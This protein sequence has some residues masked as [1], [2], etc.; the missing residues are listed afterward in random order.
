MPNSPW[1]ITGG[2]V[3][4]GKAEFYL[5]SGEQSTKVPIS[6]LT[7][8]SEKDGKVSISRD[9]ASYNLDVFPNFACPLGRFVQRDAMI[10][11]T[12]LDD[13]TDEMEQLIAGAGL[14]DS[15]IP[16]AYENSVA[17]EFAKTPFERLFER[18]DHAAITPL[19]SEIADPIVENL[20]K[21]IKSDPKQSFDK[22]AY[23]HA[24]FQVTYKIYL[25][26]KSKQIDTEGVPMRY[27]LKY[28]TGG[29][30][31]ITKVDVFSQDWSDDTKLSDLSGRPFSVSQ[32]DI[33]LAFQIAA[34]FREF[35]RANGPAFSDFVSQ[36]CKKK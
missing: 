32:Y 1:V 26:D 15:R 3:L 19:P 25:V 30:P 13:V 28:H 14:V 36:A 21:V 12:E 4:H 23:I 16:S 33:V 20:N 29:L 35:H 34:I 27:A 7:L 10:V 22:G 31:Y 8:R 18:V 17:R 6:E 24:D 9:Q 5:D 11:Y 2:V